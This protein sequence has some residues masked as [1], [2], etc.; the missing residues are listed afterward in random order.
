M[1]RTAPAI[2][3]IAQAA[4]AWKRDGFVVIDGLLPAELCT[5]ALDELRATDIIERAKPG[6]VRRA[7][8]HDDEVRFRGRQ[9]DGTTLF[10]FPGAPT[11]NRLFVHP[12]LV[13]FCAAALE[14]DDL[15]LYQSRVWSKFGDHTNYAQPHHRDVNHSLIPTRNGPGYG[16]IELFVYLHD[17]GVDTGAPR[18]APGFATG[19]GGV[20]TQRISTVDEA[21]ELYA[22]EV[23]AAGRVGSVFAYRSD[24]WHR[25]TD[26]P[27]GH[28]RH[29]L[30]AAYRPAAVDWV[31][32]DAHQPLV[33]LPDWITFVEASSPADLALFGIPRPGHEFYTA[34][35]VE[36]MSRHYPGLDVSP[37]TDALS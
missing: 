5:Q 1:T 2:A 24:V 28:E 33:S 14:D 13:A 6:P 17:V 32:F 36:G 27:E 8:Q 4:E 10:P 3:S 34:E 23:S 11:L 22:D 18:V 16:H 25:G 21:P 12:D 15:R 29:V 20:G 30:V 9:F 31:G 26:I 19:L 7:D 35:V 37:W